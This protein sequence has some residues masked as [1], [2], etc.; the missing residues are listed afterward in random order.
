MVAAVWWLTEAAEQ[1][2]PFAQY[3][4]GC[5]Y[6]KGEEILRDMAKAV[7]WLRKAALQGNEY[8]QYRLGSLYLLG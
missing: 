5:L 3:T 2:L 7:A 1:E 8:A 4:L 6:L